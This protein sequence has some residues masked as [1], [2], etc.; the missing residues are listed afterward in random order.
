VIHPAAAVTV[1]ELE[2]E[3]DTV[4]LSLFDVDDVS[5]LDER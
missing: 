5:L 4:R 1:L 3:A 2:L